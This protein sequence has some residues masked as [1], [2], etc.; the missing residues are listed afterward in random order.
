[1]VGWHGNA[2]ETAYRRFVMED[3]LGKEEEGPISDGEGRTNQRWRRKDQSA[4]EEGGP[5]S[6]G[7]GRAQCTGMGACANPLMENS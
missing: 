5:I 2:F 3:L 7:G 6:E 4:R 1:M